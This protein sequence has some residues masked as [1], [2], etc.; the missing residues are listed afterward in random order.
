[1]ASQGLLVPAA[2]HPWLRYARHG[3]SPRCLRW[4]RPL[5]A[6][7]WQPLLHGA[8]HDHHQTP[9]TSPHRRWSLRISE[10]D[11]RGCLLLAGPGIRRPAGLPGFKRSVCNRQRPVEAR[12][13]RRNRPREPSMT[14][15]IPPAGPV[16]GRRRTAGMAGHRS[17]TAGNSCRSRISG[18]GHQESFIRAS[19]FAA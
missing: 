16:A 2:R 5:S 13:A 10:P 1:M 9:R 17:L 4:R 8:G 14:C 3:T 19:R 7:G 15:D 11:G 6:C 18:S 12:L